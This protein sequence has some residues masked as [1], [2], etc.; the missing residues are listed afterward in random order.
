MDTLTEYP[1]DHRVQYPSRRTWDR[2]D[3]GAQRAK[4]INTERDQFIQPRREHSGPL[5]AGTYHLSRLGLDCL[6]EL[7][8][9]KPIRQHY[10]VL[11]E[12]LVDH[13]A[14]IQVDRC[15]G[16]VY[17]GRASAQRI[18]AKQ[19]RITNSGS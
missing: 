7:L 15:D 12:H 17:L 14:G 3:L 1:P 16:D 11:P 10:H 6:R 4:A 18:R 19:D 9:V 8:R 5:F 13:I 2:D